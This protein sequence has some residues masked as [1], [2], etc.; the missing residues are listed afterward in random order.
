MQVNHQTKE[1]ITN[2]C[3]ID[4]YLRSKQNYTGRTVDRLKEYEIVYTKNHI[5]TIKRELT[6][7][8]RSVDLPMVFGNKIGSRY[9][10]D[11]MYSEFWRTVELSLSQPKKYLGLAAYQAEAV[12]QQVGDP[13]NVLVCERDKEVH[14]WV[15][16]MYDEFL[17]KPGPLFL[18]KN[19]FDLKDPPSFSILDL[20][21]MIQLSTTDQ[22]SMI[23]TLIAKTEEPI[24]IVNITTCIGRGVSELQYDS[25]MPSHLLLLL[26][27]KGLKVTHLF[28]GGYRDRVIPM[29]YQHLVVEK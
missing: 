6:L 23:A 7:G 24:C 19:I 1:Q 20:D 25:L 3:I 10:K 14:T 28:S 26:E 12:C 8:E 16:R 21:L 29:R 27:K 11:I 17:G 15:R 13:R 9:G 18:N 4:E 5:Q 22:V 2:Y